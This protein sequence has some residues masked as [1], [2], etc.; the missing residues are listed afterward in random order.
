MARQ[1]S[2]RGGIGRTAALV[3]VA[4]LLLLGA[5]G[6]F[7]DEGG[8]VQPLPAL[9]AVEP[10]PTIPAVQ[11][12]PVRPGGGSDGCPDGGVDRA[13]GCRSTEP[14]PTASYDI[15]ASYPHD[16]AAFTQGLDWHEGT[17]YESTG[18]NGQS[19]LREVDLATGEVRRRIAILSEH[20]GEGMTIVGDR[21]VLLT[22]RSRV[23][24]VYGLADFGLQREFAYEGE[25][26]GLTHDGQALIMSDGT[27]RI[28]FL[29]PET[30]AT[31]RCIGVFD[32][33]RPVDVPRQRFSPVKTT[34]DLLALRSDAYVLADDAR[35]ELAPER[36]GTPP[37]VDLDDEHY[38]LLR[39]FDARFPA[40]APSLV[41]CSRIAV[42]GDVRFGRGVVVRGSVRIE[43][44]REVED[45]AVLEGSQ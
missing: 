34:E 19:S 1:R 44:P 23:G 11:T 9:P 33:A 8:G 13:D 15:V 3:L 28:R 29:D 45:G 4:A 7:E 6:F 39:D 30:F 31:T 21:V 27:H 22:W 42:E 2:G 16:P 43:G 38:K 14:V 37:V 12:F 36:D 26:W 17:L 20:F 24:F 5:C 10:L 35:V 25:G 41:A 18:I 40:G 32:G